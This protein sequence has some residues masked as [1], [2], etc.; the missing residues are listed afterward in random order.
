VPPFR[1]HPTPPCPRRTGIPGGEPAAGP[2][3]R[4]FGI[5][6][7][8]HP[9]R[10]RPA[11]VLLAEHALVPRCRVDASTTD[12]RHSRQWT[13]PSRG[14]ACGGPS[15]YQ[16]GQLSWAFVPCRTDSP[17]RAIV[18]A[19]L[20]R[21]S[22][23]RPYGRFAWGEA[24][25]RQD[26]AVYSPPLT[27]CAVSCSIPSLSRALRAFARRG[28]LR[29]FGSF[30]LRISI[31]PFGFPLPASPGFFSP[32]RAR[33]LRV[34]RCQLPVLK[35]SVCLRASTPLQDLSIPSRS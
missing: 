20:I 17:V 34:A 5:V 7:R 6:Y 11:N 15:C 1:R 14:R 9:L 30:R 8:S 27:T 22:D 13:H 33:S 18:G 12:S 19:R 23:R 29:A 4:S 26:A 32:D 24:P 31:G 21:L 28:V 2:R 25:C 35:P 16:A 3:R 10:G